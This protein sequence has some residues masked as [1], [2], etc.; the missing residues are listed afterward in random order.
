MLLVYNTFNTI[1]LFPFGENIFITFI[2][3]FFFSKASFGGVVVLFPSLIPR[4]FCGV[5]QC[6]Q[7]CFPGSG[8]PVW[9]AVHFLRGLILPVGDFPSH[10]SAKVVS[11]FVDD[12]D[13]SA[14]T[15]AE[16][17]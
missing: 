3:F 10:G 9:H 6:M 17:T 16:T 1:Y 5:K 4:L 2:F 11:L 7:N 8:K 14:A 12:D 15:D 13:G